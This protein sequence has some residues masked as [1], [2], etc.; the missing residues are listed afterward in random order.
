MVSDMR[1][2][3]H[4]YSI[5]TQCES[6]KSNGKFENEICK[7]C[8]YIISLMIYEQHGDFECSS[9]LFICTFLPE[10]HTDAIFTMSN[11]DNYLY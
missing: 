7:K 8:S 9:Y 2:D 5:R 4:T 11:D 1:N 10:L 3:T 6:H